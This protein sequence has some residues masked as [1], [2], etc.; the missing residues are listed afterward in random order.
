M[1][2]CTHCAEECPTVRDPDK[3]YICCALCGRIIDEDIYFTGPTFAKDS[4]GQ[5]RFAGSIMHSVQS[6]YSASHERTLM[7]GR[8]EIRHIV[9]SLR[10]GGGDSIINKAHAFYQIAVDKNFTKGRRTSQVAAACLYIACS[11]VLGAVFLQ[12][13]K[14]LSLLEH[15]IVQKLVDPSL[16]IHRFTERLLGR[17]NNAVSETALR[18]IARMKRDWMQTGRKP[19]GLCGAALYISAHSH[20][21]KYSKIDVVSVVHV[22]EATLTKRLIEFENTESGSL[23]IE[24]FLATAD[25]L[26]AESELDQLPKAGKVLCKHKDSEVPH[27]AHGLCRKCYDKFIKISGGL[28]GGA[29]PPAFQQAERRRMEKE[30]KEKKM[31]D[32]NLDNHHTY[33][34]SGSI[35]DK[36]NGSA[37]IPDIGQAEGKTTN[38]PESA[39]SAGDNSLDSEQQ[40]L[41]DTADDETE[42]FSDIDDV[43]VNGYLHNEEEKELK[44]IIWEEMNKEYLEEQAAKEAAVAAAKEAYEANFADGTEDVLAAKELAEATAA[45]LAKSRKER[46]KRRAEE[47]KNAAPAQTP[48]EAT[49]Q[50]LKK[51]TFSSKVNYEALEA[52]YTSEQDNGKKQKIESDAADPY[53]LHDNIENHGVDPGATEDGDRPEEFEDHNFAEVSYDDYNGIGDEDYG[54][55]EDFDFS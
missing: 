20:G 49:R 7:K 50:M 44:K 45:A 2:W 26:N 46:K 22:C 48:L 51:K 54:Y 31:R 25:E 3:G 53:N 36:E 39:G 6:G 38:D 41:D 37:K 15:P 33:E 43:E 16:F 9:D 10:V 28:Q 42:N 14:T 5:S 55:D 1:G 29:E 34:K 11:Y 40:D 47:S 30:E 24:E 18:I 8:D 27:F 13:C 52:L 19:S 35:H 17:K 21:L 12:L 32:S 23:T 4:S